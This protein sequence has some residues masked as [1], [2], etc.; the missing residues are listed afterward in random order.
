MR[1]ATRLMMM[2]GGRQMEQNRFQQE[3]ER[4]YSP[5]REGRRPIGFSNDRSYDSYDEGGGGTEMRRRRDSRGRYME[6]DGDAYAYG[7][8]PIRYDMNGGRSNGGYNYGGGQSYDRYGDQSYDRGNGGNYAYGGQS[9][10][11]AY[12]GGYAPS[13]HGGRERFL[14]GSGSF[15][16]QSMPQSGMAQSRQGMPRELDERM[17]REWV[18]RM[19][20]ADGSTG[21]F[22]PLEKTETYRNQFCPE[23]RKWDFY[24]AMNMMHSDYLQTAQ[25]MGV[26]KPDFYACMAKAFLCDEDAG[27]DK[28][29]KY[30]QA[31]SA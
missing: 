16:M 24:A 1:K 30:I 27:K 10:P 9:S 12:G 8:Y 19:Q 7:G 17:A 5:Q 26:D 29:V 4:E 11:M 3:R 20:N 21:E 15:E 18:A 6:G 2:E 25:K 31:V 22:Y 14:R 23:C 13:M 28:M